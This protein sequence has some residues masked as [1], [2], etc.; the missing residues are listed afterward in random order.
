MQIDHDRRGRFVR[1]SMLAVTAVV[2]LLTA[3]LLVRS[4]FQSGTISSPDAAPT[5]VS[6]RK[7]A[8]SADQGERSGDLRAA[9]AIRLRRDPNARTARMNDD[10]ADENEL[11]IDARDYI[12]ALRAEG[13]TGGIA[14]FPPPGT[15]PPESGVIVPDDYELPEGFMRHYQSTDD[16]GQLEPVLTLAPDY[17]LVDGDG[18]PVALGRDRI[19]PPE[20]APPDLPV[21][22]LDVPSANNRGQAGR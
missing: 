13:E 14:S 1:T 6:D 9:L 10:D 16:G 19:V 8:V 20:G 12:A 11:R 7:P 4:S 21:R 22:M 2:G 3:V 15:R 17:E 18:N 5:T